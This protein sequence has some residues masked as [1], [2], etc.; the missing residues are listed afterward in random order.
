[1]NTPLLLTDN[2]VK[3]FL[4]NGYLVLHPTSLDEKFHSTI[5]N[6]VSSVF[7]KEGNPGNNILPRIPEL[8]N[9]FDDPVV[10]GALESLLG[11]NYIMQPHRHAHLTKPGTQDQLW[12]KDSYF[13][14]RKELRHHQLRYIMAM[15]YP[16]DT[17][18]EM[19]PTAIKP[20]SQY[21]VLDPKVHRNEKTLENSNA[22]NDD[23]NDL[24]MI[25]QAGTVVLIHYD[26]VHKGTANRTKDSYRFMF[27]FQFNRLEEPTKPTWNHDPSNAMYDATDADLL[28]P[29]V[30]HIWNWMMGGSII[31]YQEQL[32]TE[33][34]IDNWTSQ[35]N[36]KNGKIRLNAAYNLA[37]C[38][39]YNSLIKRLS[40]NKEIFRLEAA[41]ALTACRYNKNA[42]DELKI[43]LKNQ[44]RNECPASC[45]AF[46]FSEMGSMAIDTLPLLIHVIENTD[47]WLVKRY[48]CEALGTIPLNNSP[49]VN[50]VVKCLTNILID[51]D[52]E[53]DSKDASHT[54]LTAALSLAK[55]GPN[56]NEA[57]PI[58]KDSLYQDQNRYV[59]GNALLAL[60]RI[61]TNEAL[62]IVLSYLKISRWCRKTTASSLF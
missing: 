60:E 13:G 40:N 6:Q 56:A 48:C 31:T 20:K 32:F 49:D 41:Y 1:M 28:Q 9:V 3:E 34:D 29:I 47:S 58:L 42:I 33:Q 44:K 22:K 59:S 52:Q 24:Y 53:I 57:I 26:I 43:L 61:G 4:I 45:I 51:R 19:G 23:Q 17:T 50:V 18:L 36:D 54:R 2:Q 11:T 30:K 7:E 15:Y 10:S 39:Q 21:D 37:L 38:N 25:C 12:H 62:K 14:Y 27:K 35:L 16:Q 8:Q 46:I 5:F 55:I